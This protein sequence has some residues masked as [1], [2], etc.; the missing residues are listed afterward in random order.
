MKLASSGSPIERVTARTVAANSHTRNAATR[1]IAA[2]AAPLRANTLRATARSAC[3]PSG[4][5]RHRRTHGSEGDVLEPELAL[6][7]VVA[8]HLER[9]LVEVERA[10]PAEAAVVEQ[11]QDVVRAVANRLSE[12][13][14]VRARLLILVVQ[15]AFGEPLAD[16]VERD[17]AARIEPARQPRCGRAHGAFGQIRH[18]AIPDHE[19][20][21]VR[22]AAAGRE[23]RARLLALEVARH[24]ARVLDRIS[25][26]RA[27]PLA[28][29]RLRRR[30]IELEECHA[31]AWQP[32]G[33]RVVAGTEDHDLAHVAAIDREPDQLIEIRDAQC[34]P[35]LHRRE[36]RIEPLRDRLALLARELLGPRIDE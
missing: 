31:R 23:L 15:L 8:E 5:L 10:D 9:E 7:L 29:A 28:L 27:A 13:A 12:L 1:T 30:M 3:L 19:R 24:V 35:Q 18:D 16:E 6:A 33:P 14:D 26:Q 17:E 32:C 21:F 25:G 36:P 11:R 22:V 4:P 34:E 20:R 2:G